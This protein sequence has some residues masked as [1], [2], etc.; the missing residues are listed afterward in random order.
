MHCVTKHLERERRVLLSRGLGVPLMDV[1]RRLSL[2]VR[3]TRLV[4]GHTPE[5]YTNPKR[6]LLRYPAG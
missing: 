6:R 4:L 5:S 3:L 1:L 2:P